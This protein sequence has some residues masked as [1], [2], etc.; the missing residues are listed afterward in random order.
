[1]WYGESTGGGTATYQ[2][3]MNDAAKQAYE[4]GRWQNIVWG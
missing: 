2:E 1:M 3:S 4:L